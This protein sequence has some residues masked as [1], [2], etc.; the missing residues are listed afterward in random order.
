MRCDRNKGGARKFE[1]PTSN[2]Q[3]APELLSGGLWELGVGVWG[4]ILFPYA[5]D[6]VDCESFQRNSSTNPLTFITSPPSR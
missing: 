4:L 2:S 5:A 3:E 1:R 6:S